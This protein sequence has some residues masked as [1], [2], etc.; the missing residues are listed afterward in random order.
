MS[1]KTPLSNY[2]LESISFFEYKKISKK[3]RLAVYRD[4]PHSEYEIGNKD[5][6]EM[7]FDL[8]ISLMDWGW[9]RVTYTTH[10]HSTLFDIVKPCPQ[11]LNP[12]TFNYEGGVLQQNSK[13]KN[14]VQ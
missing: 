2:I 12:Q 4:K 5:N 3:T 7:D 10:Y 13:S 11:T 8:V 1:L 9:L 6:L 14:V